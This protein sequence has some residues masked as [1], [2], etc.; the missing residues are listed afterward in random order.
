MKPI[1]QISVHS[2]SQSYSLL[3]INL[4]NQSDQIRLNLRNLQEQ[5]SE[6]QIEEVKQAEGGVPT[7]QQGII[8]ENQNQ[9]NESIEALPSQNNSTD[10]TQ[11]DTVSDIINPEPEPVIEPEPVTDP[12][13]DPIPEP[14]P[15]PVPTVPVLIYENITMEN[16]NYYMPRDS[17]MLQN[18]TL[19]QLQQ[20]VDL[21]D[22][23]LKSNLLNA[24]D[25]ASPSNN[26]YFMIEIRNI[27][28]YSQY[29]ID[30]LQ[31]QWYLIQIDEEFHDIQIDIMTQDYLALIFSNTLQPDNQYQIISEISFQ[32]MSNISNRYQIFDFNTFDFQSK[33]LSITPQSGDAY[34]TVFNIQLI[35]H[36][37]LLKCEIYYQDYLA[38]DNSLNSSAKIIIYQDSNYSSQ[39]IK[40]NINLPYSYLGNLRVMSQC[41]NSSSNPTFSNFSIKINPIK[42][43]GIAISKLDQTIE[44]LEK[45]FDEYQLLMAICLIQDFKVKMPYQNLK[46]FIKQIISMIQE[47]YQLV[48]LLNL[49]VILAEISDLLLFRREITFH[50]HDIFPQIFEIYEYLL[51][52]NNVPADILNLMDTEFNYQF[53]QS[54]SQQ[55]KERIDQNLKLSS[56]LLKVYQL[57]S[58]IT[59]TKTNKFSRAFTFIAN[60]MSSHL[61]PLE[62]FEYEQDLFSIYVKKFSG[63]YLKAIQQRKLRLQL[64]GNLPNHQNFT[65]DIPLLDP[66]TQEQ[67]IV[68]RIIKISSIFEH[69]NQYHQS[70]SDSVFITLLKSN[71]TF[72][73]KDQ[74]YQLQKIDIQNLKRPVWFL[75]PIQEITM[76]QNILFTNCTYFDEDK[77][78]WKDTKCQQNTLPGEA[79]ATDLEEIHYKSRLCCTRHLSKFSIQGY[80]TGVVQLNKLE[81]LNEN[82]NYKGY[83]LGLVAGLDLTLIIFIIITLR[84]DKNNRALLDQKQLS[85]M[86]G[87]SHNPKQRQ[88]F[89]R[90]MRKAQVEKIKKI[91]EI[92][93]ENQQ[94]NAIVNNQAQNIRIRQLQQIENPEQILNISDGEGDGELKHKG[95]MSPGILSRNSEQIQYEIH[96]DPQNISMKSIGTPQN[97]NQHISFERYQHSEGDINNQH[98]GVPSTGA[99]ESNDNNQLESPDSSSAS[100]GIIDLF[101]KMKMRDRYLMLLR[102]QHRIVSCFYLAENKMFLR[103]IKAINLI[104]QSFFSLFI[105]ALFASYVSISIIL[106]L[107]VQQYALE[108]RYIMIAS[109]LQLPLHFLASQLLVKGFY[110]T[111]REMKILTMLIFMVIIVIGHVLT[112]VVNTGDKIT[113]RNRLLIPYLIVLGIQYIA[114]DMIIAPLLCFIV[115][116]CKIG[117]KFYA[118]MIQHKNDFE[119]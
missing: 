62:T 4:T 104:A 106:I 30:Q 79:R 16:L 24:N 45:E 82:Y 56:I 44:R 3:K 7:D 107:F 36:K 91:K 13:P 19:N 90:Q 64:G 116:R 69:S 105:V 54:Q 101:Q 47:R 86:V 51:Y 32:N 1:N 84:L 20:I 25:Y 71:Q 43:L 96:D 17:T 109:I 83:A 50:N 115:M 87:I 37:Q 102:F 60:M 76:D 28:L 40:L 118:S 18:L 31:I 114:L 94:I 2:Q 92:E 48:Q 15:E 42:G 34:T 55:S 117:Q 46:E 8:E 22:I 113:S 12:I 93:L 85:R 73:Q 110:F 58:N 65:I 98:I 9:I 68:I 108:I 103:P 112:I 80:T 49:R 74:F 88:K 21:M 10:Q 61:F 119:L 29:F 66:I 6:N 99:I 11:N 72:L 77:G 59:E 26:N 75:L 23:K 5:N 53:I 67:N 78:Q 97:M 81:L 63:S 95:H 14:V 57:E 39:E 89:I 41:L 38:N 35:K 111:N 100:S 27:R 33:A 70:I 52:Q